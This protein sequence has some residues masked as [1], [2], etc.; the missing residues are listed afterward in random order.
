MA[1][2]SL[3]ICLFAIIAVGLISAA[4][5]GLG[6]VKGVLWHIVYSDT[7][8]FYK[9]IAGPGLPYLDKNIEYPVITGWFMQLASWLGQTRAGYFI[10][11]SL[12][13]IIL[14]ALATYF[15]SLILA[16]SASTEANASQ[17]RKSEGPEQNREKLWL[18]WIFAPSMFFFSTYNWD[19]IAVLFVVLAFYFSA[20]DQ[21][22]WAAFFLALGFSAKFYPIIYLP[23]LILKNP[24]KWLK[25]TGVFVAVTVFLNF[26]FAFLNF[27][28]WSYFFTLNNL[29][30]S[31]PDSIWT[32]ARFFFRNLDVSTINFL[33]L[34]FFGGSYLLLLWKQRNENLI[35]L[36]FAATLLFLI[37][38]KVFSPQ[39]ILWLLPFLV[40]LPAVKK[41]QFYSLEL[42]NLMTFFLILPWHFISKDIFYFYLSAPFVL[43]RHVVLLTLLFYASR[44]KIL[45]SKS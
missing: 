27:E 23:I 2:Q 18:Y 21:N 42:S 6:L 15:L 5:H 31:N 32:I 16:R 30:N 33:S 13:L 29:R 43:I 3:R 35:K 25:I 22:G 37:F 1:S 11:N 39:Y 45:N 7:L 14:A 4:F 34:L 26:P 28:G 41:W 19:L 8:G 24:K 36:C 10:V 9:K 17:S 12:F 38:N 20:K 44:D 40:L